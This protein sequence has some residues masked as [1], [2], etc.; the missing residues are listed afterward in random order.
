MTQIKA[1]IFAIIFSINFHYDEW[2]DACVNNAPSGIGSRTYWIGHDNWA[3][4]PNSASESLIFVLVC[5]CLSRLFI[6]YQK[7]RSF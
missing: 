1:K 2:S 4:S 6:H 5:S 7:R 3:K